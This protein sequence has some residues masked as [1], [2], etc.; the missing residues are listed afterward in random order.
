MKAAVVRPISPNS[1][2]VGLNQEKKG[3][4]CRLPGGTRPEAT[5]PSAD[6][7][8][9]G[10][11]NDA[12]PKTIP[13]RRLRLASRFG[14]RIA[15]AAPRSTSPRAAS[16][17]AAQVVDITDSKTTGKPVQVMISTNTSHMLLDSHTGAIA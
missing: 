9:Y 15:N 10:V 13:S 1:T 5:P 6:A 8:K 3:S 17:R 16:I 2:E 12:T 4:P 11:M 14:F 7:R